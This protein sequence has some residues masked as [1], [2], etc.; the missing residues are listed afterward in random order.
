[1]PASCSQPESARLQDN[2][3]QTRV[4]AITRTPR[5]LLRFS[6]HVDDFENSSIRFRETSIGSWG[7]FVAILKPR[8]ASPTRNHRERSRDRETFD[9]AKFQLVPGNML[10]DSVCTLRGVRCFGT[11]ESDANSSYVPG[12]HPLW[13]EI[14]SSSWLVFLAMI[15]ATEVFRVERF[16]ER[17]MGLSI[18]IVFEIKN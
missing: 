15:H 16:F 3:R 7:K 2:L 18:R 11:D 14:Y 9:I 1:M 5:S 6:Q 4:T 13:N 17:Q 12:E 8:L 10:V